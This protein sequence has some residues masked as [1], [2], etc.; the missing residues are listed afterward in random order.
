MCNGGTLPDG[1]AVVANTECS[2]YSAYAGQGQVMLS[3]TDLTQMPPAPQ[4]VL[5]NPS[6][7]GSYDALGMRGKSVYSFTGTVTY[8]SGGTQWTIEARC[9][10]DIITTPNT[11]PVATGGLLDP[12]NPNN[13]ACV[14]PR[15]L[16]DNNQTTP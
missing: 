16:A 1:T 12:N 3:V 13:I 14:Q 15:S 5:V 11:P 10:Q 8:F 9:D 2:E 4:K 6:A 7:S